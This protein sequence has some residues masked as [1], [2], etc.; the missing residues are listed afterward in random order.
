FE[1]D[2]EEMMARREELEARKA[3]LEA[4]RERLQEEIERRRQSGRSADDLDDDEAAMKA[5]MEAMWK[6]ETEASWS[7]AMLEDRMKASLLTD[8][9]RYAEMDKI[10]QRTLEAIADIARRAIEEGRAEEYVP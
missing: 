5:E 9:T 6:A 8:K 10:H 1:R 7:S 2:R 4:R 3:K